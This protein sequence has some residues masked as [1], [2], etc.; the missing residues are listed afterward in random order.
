MYCVWKQTNFKNLS[1]NNQFCSISKIETF[2][3]GNITIDAN[4]P[5]ITDP[6]GGSNPIVVT[7]VQAI[8]GVVHAVS[9]VIRD[10]QE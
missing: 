5:A 3:G 2:G 1:R 10:L 7:D 8:N 6:D 9:R 4:T